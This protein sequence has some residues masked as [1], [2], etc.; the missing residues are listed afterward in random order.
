[1]ADG[2]RAADLRSVA[3]RSQPDGLDRR[4]VRADAAAG[5]RRR[6]VRRPV[7]RR[8]A[9]GRPRGRTHDRARRHRHH[10]SGRRRALPV[11]GVLAGARRDAA[12]AGRGPRRD[13][14]PRRGHLSRRVLRRAARPEGRH[15]HR[16]L[17]SRQQHRSRAAP[18][19]PDRPRRLSPRRSARG[20]ARP[21]HRRLLPLASGSP[22]RAV[23]VRPRARVA[24]PELRDRLDSPGRR[25]ASCGPGG[26]A[27]IAPATTK[28]PSLKE[29]RHAGP[30]S[31]SHSASPVHR[32]AG[33]RSPRRGPPSA[34]C[35]AR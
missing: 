20:R 11:R 17:A 8:G 22:G 2:A 4:R 16:L 9:R 23:G 15:G 18:P 1:M 35:C 25:R 24:E 5:A 19:L 12:A 31:R 13:P 29:T 32:A 21:R 14:R 28:S 34:S 26:C 30:Y 6:T 27:P 3:R 33:G 10:L 7:E